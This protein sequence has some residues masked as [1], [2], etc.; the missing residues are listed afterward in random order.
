MITSKILSTLA[1]LCL[2]SI[3][4]S[5]EPEKDILGKWKIDA[6]SV[7]K[8]SRSIIDF[9]RKTKPES[10]DQMEANFE[11][12]ME[13]VSK[14]EYDFT[15]DKTYR[16]K[17]AQNTQNGTWEITDNGHSIIFN[18]PDKPARKDSIL[19]LNSSRLVLI[20]KERADTI[21]YT[22]PQ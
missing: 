8:A 5:N 18:R 1:L 16:L 3:T 17:S 19:E 15:A 4:V 22:R 7:E 12:V 21:L 6:S 2:S 11:A 14:I 9:T 13:L 10:A 20:N